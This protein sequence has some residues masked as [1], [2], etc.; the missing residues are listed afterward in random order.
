MQPSVPE[1]APEGAAEPFEPVEEVIVGSTSLESVVSQ[2][3]GLP[4][5]VDTAAVETLAQP[6]EDVALP[7]TQ[8]DALSDASAELTPVEPSPELL[9]KTLKRKRGSPDPPSLNLEP[10]ITRSQKAKDGNAQSS[11][12][13]SPTVIS[14]SQGDT[15]AKKAKAKGSGKAAAAKKGKGKA[16][17]VEE[18]REEEEESERESVGSAASATSATKLQDAGDV[19]SRQPSRAASVAESDSASSLGSPTTLVRPGP[20]ALP[21]LIHSHTHNHSF[22]HHHHGRAPPPPPPPPVI[23]RTQTLPGI[24]E[25]SREASVDTEVKAPSRSQPEPPLKRGPPSYHSPVTRSNCRFHVISLPSIELSETDTDEEAEA[26]TSRPRKEDIPRSTFIVPGCS[27]GD[28]ELMK[29]KDIKDHGFATEDDHRRMVPNIEDLEFDAYLVGVLRQLV[30]VDLLRENEVFWLPGP[31]EKMKRKKRRRV[32]ESLAIGLGK[33]SVNKA[34]G[35]L[36]KGAAGS[37]PGEND[38]SSVGKKSKKPRASTT[39]MDLREFANGLEGGEPAETSASAPVGRFASVTPSVLSTRDDDAPSPSPTQPKNGDA[40]LIEEV[41][42]QEEEE[43]LKNDDSPIPEQIARREEEEEKEESS[44]QEDQEDNEEPQAKRR[45]LSSPPLDF[46]SASASASPSSQQSSQAPKPRARRSLKKPLNPDA[47]A[48]KPGAEGD[49]VEESSEEEGSKKGRR[50]Y[51]FKKRQNPVVPGP[52]TE[53]VDPALP[54]AS[55]S[56]APSAVPSTVPSVVPT[57][58]ASA[59]PSAAASEAGGDTPSQPAEEKPTRL[60]RGK[61]RS[62]HP[63]AAAYNPAKDGDGDEADSEEVEVPKTRR[64]KAAAGPGKR[65]QKRKQTADGEAEAGGSVNG[66]QGPKPKRKRT[67]KNAAVANSVPPPPPTEATPLETADG[68]KA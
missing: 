14:S 9:P 8:I 29:E 48:Y 41:T 25:T 42:R 3:A 54:S 59:A 52:P 57:P 12:A 51:V 36:G 65:G 62:I 11:P 37:V 64:G 43:E 19:G 5:L 55:P 21:S 16:K 40:P 6:L 44:E 2:E 38:S 22:M 66:E 13:T 49:E 61:R 56:A 33:G 31:G 18:E 26:S 63:D 39:S 32:T 58:S 28:G 47:Q 1:S 50:K 4:G 10:R 34:K 20:T 53:A 24:A 23:A 45:K 7:A 46:Q 35:S 15:V 60:K 27:L 30:G 17:Q 67:K 68:E